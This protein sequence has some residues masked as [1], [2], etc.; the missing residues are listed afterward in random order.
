MAFACQSVSSSVE[1]LATA[2][3]A[4]AAG[5]EVCSGGIFGIGET[6]EQELAIALLALEVD[7]VPLNFL[8]PIPGTLMEKGKG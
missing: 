1:P 5:L 3:A 8:V 7:V 6:D 4:K 2:R